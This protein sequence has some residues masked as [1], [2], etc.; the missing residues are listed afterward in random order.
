MCIEHL[1]GLVP[2]LRGRQITKVRPE[3]DIRLCSGFLQ[4]E[5][6][7]SA[8][9]PS[10]GAHSDENRLM[11]EASEPPTSAGGRFLNRSVTESPNASARNRIGSESGFQR[12]SVWRRSKRQIQ[13]IVQRAQ[14]HIM[15]RAKERKLALVISNL[16]CTRFKI[17]S[18]DSGGSGLPNNLGEVIYKTSVLHLQPRQMAVKLI[19]LGGN[20]TSSQHDSSTSGPEEP[21]NVSGDFPDAGADENLLPRLLDEGPPVAPLPGE[22]FG[23]PPNYF[24]VTAMDDEGDIPGPSHR[25]ALAAEAEDRLMTQASFIRLNH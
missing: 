17:T 20:S 5:I 16:W 2:V 7:S 13:Q 10:A 21:S 3:F 15:I 18:L 9:A 4:A 19:D 11:R 24:A 8:A 14:Q 22:I 25:P 1:G 6:A 23:G 12:D